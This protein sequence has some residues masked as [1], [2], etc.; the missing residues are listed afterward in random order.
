MV[1]QSKR[2]YLARIKDR[3]RSDQWSL[4][5]L[6]LYLL[7]RPEAMQNA[8]LKLLYEVTTGT[9]SLLQ[10]FREKVLNEWQLRH[11]EVI[12]APLRAL[13]KGFAINYAKPISQSK[14]S[15]SR[16]AR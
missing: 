13:R 14:Y 16:G 2:E 15:D 8:F 12:A 7:S 6:F 3:Y 10:R 11:A 9:C 5:Q 1:A 4:A